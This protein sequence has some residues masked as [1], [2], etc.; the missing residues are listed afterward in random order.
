LTEAIE[1]YE[2]ALQLKP[3]FAG[4]YCNLGIA[5]ARQGKL[6][7]AVQHFERAL[8]IE[9]DFAE[10][11]YNLGNAL[12]YLGM[13]LAAEGQFAEAIRNYRRAI[14]ANPDRPEIYFHLGMALGQ[15]GRTRDAL[16]QY[17]EA[18]RLNP[19]LAGA[20]NNLA[21]ILATSS[22][23]GLRNG[24]E[25]IRLAERA[26]ELTHHDKPLYIGTLAAAYAEAGRFSEAVATA[27]RAEQLA[28]KAGLTA[29]AEKNRQA[30]EFY[31]TGK[32]YHEPQ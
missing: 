28:T 19:E 23:D 3:N 12:D 22:D 32:S 17:Q 2:R 16:V 6:S 4:A 24:A 18:L 27:E 26:C 13:A 30:L 7:E 21:W 1:Q 14:Q 25:A 10:A 11:H 29:V 15:S 20:L 8:Q 5:L 31:R 9:P